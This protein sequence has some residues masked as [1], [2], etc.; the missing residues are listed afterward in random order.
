VHGA[1][2]VQQQLLQQLCGLLTLLL[3]KP[4]HLLLNCVWVM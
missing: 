3:R 2:E 1:L 4:M